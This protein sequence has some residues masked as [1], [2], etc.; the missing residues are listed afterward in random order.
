MSDYV[1]TREGV[2]VLGRRE[3]SCWPKTNIVWALP[4]A[5]WNMRSCSLRLSSDTSTMSTRTGVVPRRRERAWLRHLCQPS[6]AA[7]TGTDECRFTRPGVGTHP[8]LL[9]TPPS[10]FVQGRAS[11]AGKTGCNVSGN[12]RE[13]VHGVEVMHR[14]FQML[15]A[16]AGKACYGLLHLPS[17]FRGAPRPPPPQS[18][19]LHRLH[20][21]CPYSRFCTEKEGSFIMT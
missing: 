3:T 19:H 11:C 20:G 14:E 2:V 5:A 9:R 13:Q 7:R 1:F 15:G 8:R 16:H 6:T 4:L 12:F 10:V 18:L 21:E 17:G